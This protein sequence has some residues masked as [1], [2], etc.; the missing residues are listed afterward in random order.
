MTADTAL[1]TIADFSTVWVIA[2]VFEYEA[3]QVHIGQAASMTLP[4]LDAQKDENL[5]ARQ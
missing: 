2:D 4:Y 5:K 1:Y 3:A